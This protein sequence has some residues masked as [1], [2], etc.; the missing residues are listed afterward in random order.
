MG[1]MC[2]GASKQQNIVAFSDV[3]TERA[4][5]SY[6]KHPQVP[7]YQ[8]FRKMLEKHQEEID[9]VLISTPDHTHFPATMAAMELGIHVF[10]Q[11]PL[12]HDI[13]QAR[14]LQKAEDHY[15]VKAVM[16]NQGRCSNGIRQIKEWID[17]G[18][19]G[20]VAE[21]HAWTVRPYEGWGSPKDPSPAPK[22]PIPQTLDWD[23]WLG[24]TLFRDYNN[25]YLPSKWRAW[26]DFGNSAM[27]DIGCHLLDSVYWAL[28]LKGSVSVKAEAESY[29]DQITPAKGIVRLKYP[30]RGQSSGYGSLVRRRPET[31]DP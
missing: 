12:T 9:V 4:S 7:T 17:A 11:K 15:K 22:Q 25:C 24:P 2:V 28:D 14:T 5:E 27:G 19:I 29:H 20:D 8:D 18:L 21:V 6:Q 10:T 13:W 30:A 23:T 31:A 3:D 16:G 26:W 1:T